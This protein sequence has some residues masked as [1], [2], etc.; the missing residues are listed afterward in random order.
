MTDKIKILHIVDSFNIGGMENILA[1]LI[2]ESSLTDFHHTICCIKTSGAAA[3]RLASPV[4][5]HELRKKE[6]QSWF[7]FRH[8][9]KVLREENPDIVH[10]RS[11]GTTD[12]IIA[13]RLARIPVVIHGEHGWSFEDPYGK[14]R[15]RLLI[16]RALSPFV[17]HYI[18]IS[19]DIK[20]WL[21]GSVGINENRITTIINGVDVNKFSPRKQTINRRQFPDVGDQIVIGAVGR[22]DPIK[23]YDLLVEAFSQLDHAKHNLKLIIAGDGSE[24]HNLE[25][26]I[27]SLPFGNRIT[28]LGECR[29]V[30]DIYREM[31]LFIQSSQNEGISNTVLEAMASGLPVIG[32]AVGGNPQLISNGRTGILIPPNSS[33][34]IREAITFYLDHPETIIFHGR[35]SREAAKTRFS[36]SRMVKNYQDLYRML[37]SRH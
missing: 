34:A 19:D 26:R 20:Q 24:R 1:S 31:S 8:L 30:H 11:W 36:L 18:A 12:G 14:N 3:A 32:T 16:R 4:T 37:Y 23:R 2:N 21:Q 25:T 6:G 5:I 17:T 33:H 27:R 28:L 7:F 35:N 29:N 15:K 22:L 9:T 13:A 10:T